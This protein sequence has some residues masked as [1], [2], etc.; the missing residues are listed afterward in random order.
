LKFVPAPEY[1]RLLVVSVDELSKLPTVLKTIM[2]LNPEGVETFDIHTFERAKNFLKSE[3][4]TCQKFFTNKTSLVVLAQFS[5]SDSES[6]DSMARKCQVELEKNAKD[7]QTASSP[8]LAFSV[9]YVDN[10]E[11]ANSIWKIRRSSFTAMRDWNP[12]GMH[13]VPCIEDII[14]PIDQF[15]IFVPSLIALI[16]KYELEYGFHGHI[17][18]G[19]LRIIPVFDFRIEKK[20]LAQR[21]ISFTREA[22]ALVKSLEG[23]MSADHSD[24]IIRSPFIKEFYGPEVYKAFVDIKEVFDPLYILNKGKKV[25][26]LEENIEKYLI[27]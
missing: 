15:G 8:D 2:S 10:P 3:T 22:I 13:A 23:N 11:V 27:D 1:T 12:E 14:V 24:G 5:E 16:K 18:D 4:A 26:G 9:T 17:G 7:L 25:G 6:T 21:I 20:V 19:S